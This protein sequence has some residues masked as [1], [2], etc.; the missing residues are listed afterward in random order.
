MIKLPLLGRWPRPLSTRRLILL[1]TVANLGVAALVIGPTGLAFSTAA[2][3]TGDVTLDVGG[4]KVATSADVPNAIGEA[5][6]NGEGT[7]VESRITVQCGMGSASFTL[8]TG[9]NRG[10]C[11]VD[12]DRHGT[13]GASC[14]DGHGNSASADCSSGGSC[15]AS[16]GSGS[17]GVATK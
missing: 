1:A 14:D 7:A 11:K 4:T 8:S 6:K 13:N 17:C 12:R 5:H 10:S 2:A 3:E 9:N 16:S 15:T